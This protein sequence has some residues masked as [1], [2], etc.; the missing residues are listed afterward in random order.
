MSKLSAAAAIFVP[1]VGFV[2]TQPP[3]EEI[4]DM[5]SPLRLRDLQEHQERCQ[6]TIHELSDTINR[7]QNQLD[8]E[9]LK[10]QKK[11][12]SN[13]EKIIQEKEDQIKQIKQKIEMDSIAAKRKETM[14]SRMRETIS[15][16]YEEIKQLKSKSKDYQKQVKKNKEEQQK[17]IRIN[18]KLREENE[19]MKQFKT[20]FYELRNNFDDY[21]GK[22]FIKHGN[23]VREIDDLK[24]IVRDND[25]WMKNTLRLKWI[26]DEMEKVGAIRLPDHHWAIDMAHDIEFS[27]QE[28]P[29]RS[30]FRDKIPYSLYREVLPNYD[31]AE[32]QFVDEETENRLIDE[33]SREAHEFSSQIGSG[34]IDLITENRDKAVEIIILIQS[35][36]RGFISRQRTTRLFGKTMEERSTRINAA[37]RIQSIYRGFVFRGHRNF[38]P[39]IFSNRA[40]QYPKVWYW[41]N[42]N[43]LGPSHYA[44]WGHK[45]SL[46]RENRNLYSRTIKFFN[47]GKIDE[48]YSYCW[49]NP[50]TRIFGQWIKIEKESLGG[51]TRVSTY[52]GHWIKITNWLTYETFWIRVNFS[53]MK[54]S[55][56]DLNTRIN[57]SPSLW[58]IQ[59]RRRFCSIVPR[60]IIHNE[61]IPINALVPRCNCSTC[62]MRIEMQDQDLQRLQIAIQMSLDFARDENK[63]ISLRLTD[64]VEEY[65]ISYLFHEPDENTLIRQ[66]QDEEYSRAE[67][68]DLARQRLADDVDTEAV[69]A[70]RLHRFN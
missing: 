37:T 67:Q 53:A 31:D 33:L 46:L 65:N 3:E 69:R 26:I 54:V 13:L 34:I 42:Q 62:Q 25:L 14:L 45:T 63:D 15:S 21:R 51:G 38:N 55:Y 39:S 11:E 29:N 68:I 70:V 32:I 6:S 59:N 20:R 24:Q 47:S 28:E 40:N 66:R 4:P 57:I 27:N 2:P 43:Q 7:L 50:V 58:E 10:S 17:L 41:D 48:N 36:I 1:P 61:D 5:S 12:T 60:N 30:V 18:F 35:F 16:H 56:F 64:D 44:I 49:F 23:L 22:E 52:V 19:V 9:K 8:E